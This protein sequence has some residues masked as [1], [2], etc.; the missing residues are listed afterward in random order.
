MQASFTVIKGSQWI[1]VRFEVPKT[2][3]F[4]DLRG[5]LITVIEKVDGYAGES[6]LAV[7][8]TTMT[9]YII[10]VKVLTNSRELLNAKGKLLEG[11]MDVVEPLKK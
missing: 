5:K 10:I 3:R 11:I 6:K 8:E 1:Q 4:Y 9:S 7:D 2:I